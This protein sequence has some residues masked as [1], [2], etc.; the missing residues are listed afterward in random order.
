VATAGCGG[1]EGMETGGRKGGFPR[2]N[3]GKWWFYPKKWWK[4]VVLPGKMVEHG[5]FT[6]VY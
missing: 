2:K 4:M 5:G 1:W 6:M 3:G